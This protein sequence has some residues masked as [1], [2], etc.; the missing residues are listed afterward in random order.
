M[1][2]LKILFV[3]NTSPLPESRLKT[4]ASFRKLAS[5]VKVLFTYDEGYERNL[6][7]RLLSRLKVPGDP[8]H[9]N[10]RIREEAIRFQPGLVFIVKGQNIRPATLG[11]LQAR[12]IKTVSWSNDDMWGRHNRTVWYSRGLK[13]YDLVVTQKSYNADPG[14]LPS[15][16]ARV[17]FQNKAFDPSMHNPV[18]DCRDCQAAHP[19]LF[20]GTHE[21]ERLRSL[22]YLAANGIRV[23]VYGWGKKMEAGVHPNLVFHD[24]HLYGREYAAAFSCSGICLNFLRKKSRDLQTSRSVEIPACR[25]FMLAERTGEHLALFQEGIEAEYFSSDGEL[26]QKVQYYLAH[27]YD[28]KR[29]AEA[30]FQRCLKE[31]YSFDNRIRE[32]LGTVLSTNYTGLHE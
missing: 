30:G 24:R 22:Q 23:D 4:L 18:D 16:G 1:K 6:T 3:Y 19:V 32:I 31:D 29:I 14:E 5:G 13:H 26:L 10:R 15:L 27:P 25:G 20:I 7:D 9:I 2:F 12:G 28:R 8:C 17:L 11:F 21:K